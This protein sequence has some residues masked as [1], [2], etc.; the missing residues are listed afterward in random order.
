MMNSVVQTSLNHETFEK[1]C[2]NLFILECLN[3][4][5]IQIESVK[6]QYKK[7]HYREI[8]NA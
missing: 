3:V 1:E 8:V 7:P 4:M 5:K 2:N 6:T